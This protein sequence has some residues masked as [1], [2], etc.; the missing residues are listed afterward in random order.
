MTKHHYSL[1][2]RKPDC[3]AAKSMHKQSAAISADCIFWCSDT[4]QHNINNH[5][6]FTTKP[7]M[8]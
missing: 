1:V 8:L 6:Y 7:Q 3:Q 2:Y 5:N 4:G